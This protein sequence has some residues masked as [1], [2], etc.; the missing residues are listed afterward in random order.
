MLDIHKDTEGHSGKVS[1][2]NKYRLLENGEKVIFVIKWQGTWLKFV[3][4][5]CGR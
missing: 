5:F 2:A 4:V 3:L 1:D